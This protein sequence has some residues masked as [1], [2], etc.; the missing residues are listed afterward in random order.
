MHRRQGIGCE[1]AR[2]EFPALAR[3]AKIGAEQRLRSGRAKTHE[4]LRFDQLD[5]FVE[6]RQTGGDFARVGLLV[7]APLSARRPFEMLDDIRDVRIGG[8]DSRR[9]PYGNY[10]TTPPPARMGSPPTFVVF[11]LL[12][13]H[14]DLSIP[15]PGPPHRIARIVPK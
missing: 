13:A 12:P 11:R 4:D 9:P 1:A 8:G 3:D 15:T 2:H 14:H 7:D 6:P 10:Y 5:L